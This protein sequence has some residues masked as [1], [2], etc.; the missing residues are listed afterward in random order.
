MLTFIVGMRY[1][2]DD[3]GFVTPAL[4][5]I[6]PLSVVFTFVPTDSSTGRAGISPCLLDIFPFLCNVSNQHCAGI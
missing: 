4:S 5:L 6:I 1:G 2:M 3:I